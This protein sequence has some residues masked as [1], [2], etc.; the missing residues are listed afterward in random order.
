MRCIA[1]KNEYPNP[2]IIDGTA[3]FV[4]TECGH[5]YQIKHYHPC[6]K[7]QII[8]EIEMAFSGVVLGEGIGLFEGQAL[9][10]YDSEE[11]QKKQ[12]VKDEKINWNTIPY[13][14]LQRCRS[15]LSF[16]DADGMRFHLPA[17]LIGSIKG[18]VDDPI[19]QLTH[20]DRHFE[21]RMASLNKLQKKCIIEYLNWCLAQEEYQFNHEDIVKALDEF[22]R[23]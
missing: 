21:S 2:D 12:R 4:C 22:W 16:F 14:I 5:V 19:F 13:D 1:C 18:K 3:Y 9:D 15:S 8:A 6:T 7:A 17:Y 11:V 23:K 20:M 10:D